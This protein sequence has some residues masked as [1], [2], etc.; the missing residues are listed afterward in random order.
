MQYRCLIL[1]FLLVTFSTAT[2][3]QNGSASA[4]SNTKTHTTISIKNNLLTLIVKDQSLTDTLDLISKHHQVRFSISGKLDRGLYNWRII[5]MPLDDA[6]HSILKNHSVV[7][8]YEFE[9]DYKTRQLSRVEILT[10]GKN[11]LLTRNKS[12]SKKMPDDDE[13]YRKVDN[14]QGLKD[15]ITVKLLTSSL[16]TNM[17][18]KARMRAVE[19]LENIGTTESKL[20]VESAL[21]DKHISVRII[22]LNLLSKRRNEQSILFLGQ[23]LNSDPDVQIRVLALKNLSTFNSSS[24]KSFIQSALQDNN[25]QVR[26]MALKLIQQ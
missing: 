23:T 10:H 22:T 16:K 25:K 6:I 26:N 18:A 13:N 1:L 9:S 4:N 3:A 12:S 7:M 20:A 14:L 5:Q 24:A 19:L 2:T 17:N 8:F 15:P 11:N 21:G